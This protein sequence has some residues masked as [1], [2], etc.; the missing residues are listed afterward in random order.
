MPEP[1]GVIYD[2]GYQRYDGPR[3]GRRNA[4]LALY[5]HGLRGVFGLG[6]P[7]KSKVLPW[8]AVAIMFTPMIVLIAVM[9]RTGLQVERY[10]FYPFQ[11]QAVL[12]VFLAAQAPEL[13]SRDQRYHVLPL[14]FSRPIRR[15]D[16]ALA[17]LAAMIT[18][19]FAITAGPLLVY[20]LGSIATITH[21]AGD[22][23]HQTAQFAV[24]VTNAIFHA[25]LLGALGMAIAAFS[26]RRAFATVSVIAVYII[27][28]AVAGA[29]SGLPG[30]GGRYAELFSPFTLLDGLRVWLLHGKV[31]TEA[32][33]ASAAYGAVALAVVIA[34]VFALLRRYDKLTA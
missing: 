11:L 12:A 16:Y 8:L 15:S 3:L 18:A 30:R 5:I 23:R 26:A 9:S 20:Y 22:F 7:T 13:L 2:I 10:D 32:A 17:K 29:L 4:A 21:N 24:G 14:Y 27:T 25:V 28:S 31:L 33:A 6:R 34:C 19:I 1:T